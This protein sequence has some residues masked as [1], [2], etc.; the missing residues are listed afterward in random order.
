MARGQRVPEP[1]ES[2]PARI[3]TN[4]LVLP[5][6]LL[7]SL[8]WR[9]PSLF[10]PPWVNDEGTYFAV[11]QAMAHGYRLYD[12]VWENKPPA[13]YLLYSAVY[14]PFGASLIA[15]RLLTAVAVL[16]L[17]VTV[18]RLAVHFVGAQWAPVA[19]MLAG[20]LFG[21]PFLEG[22]TGN[23]EV[24][25]A[26]FSALAVEQAILK[27]RLWAAGLLMAVATLFKAVAVFDAV[28]LGL[29]L[30]SGLAH[31]SAPKP[32]RRRA[33]RQSGRSLRRI[34]A[35]VACYFGLLLAACVLAQLAGILQ[36]MLNDALLYD[37][38]YVGQANGGSVPWLLLVKL[39]LLAV[40]VAA[41]W[42]RSFPALWLVFAAFGALFGGRIF[43]HYLLQPVVPLV[44]VLTMAARNRLQPGRVL[45]A[46]PVAFLAAG[47]LAGAVGWVD[48]ASGHDSILARRLQYYPNFFRLALRRQSYDAYVSEIDDHVLRNEAAA[49]AL[50]RLPA[51][52]L[53]VWGNTPWIYVLSGRL[54][55]TP[56]TSAIRSPEVPGETSSLRRAVMM[57]EPSAIV[58]IR[59]PAPPLEPGA[60]PSLHRRYRL[61]KVIGEVEVYARR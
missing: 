31:A 52:T 13:L 21:A 47:L 33:E 36:G 59:P 26:L 4:P 5:A 8:L 58:V 15:I 55:A 42:K 25:V 27:Q 2:A 29:W 32:A 3:A 17:V 45:K 40:L 9:L 34:A 60:T 44:L 48:A 22:T 54:P 56:Y 28:A 43:G 35:Y 12:G 57:A 19:A 53:L 51:G 37:L 41:V 39:A 23:A 24:F 14:H 38:G 49:R 50:E 10:D 7:V 30:F 11:A 20:L 6:V 61:V 16:A 1:T 46:L 18:W